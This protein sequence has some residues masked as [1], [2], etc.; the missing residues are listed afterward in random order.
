VTRQTGRQE[1]PDRK[2]ARF[3]AFSRAAAALSLTLMA[4]PTASASAAGITLHETGSTLLYPLFEL[5]IRD[6]SNLAPGVTL[7][8]A[9]TGSGA[10][11]QQAIAGQAQIGASDAYMSDEQVA[12]NP[13]IKN[14]PL[15]I[16]AQTVN[17]NIPGLNGAGLKLDGPSLA[18]IYAGRITQWDEASIGEMNPGVKLPRE[19]VV[20]IRR[21]EASGDTFIFT[22]FLDFSTQSWAD[23]IGYGSTVAWPAASGAKNATGNEGM[24]QTAAATPY[25]VAYIGISFRQAIAKAGL[26]TAPLKNQNGKFVLPTAETI[27]AGASVLDPRTPPD[28]RLSLVFAAGDN[29]YPLINYEYAVVSIRQA[30]P[31]TAKALREFLLWAIS[32]TGGNAPKYLDAV[33]F[34]PLPDFIRALSQKQIDLIK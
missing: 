15:A 27:D 26:G 1:A 7:T 24:V 12:Q 11:E 4:L 16:S 17:Y 25:S 34:I 5:W 6:Y 29:S 18:G 23:K 30:N 20:P 10:G 28:Q 14:I 32:L 13:E 2:S 9:A 22:Q 31:E 3:I 21:A 33:G 8:A 19:T